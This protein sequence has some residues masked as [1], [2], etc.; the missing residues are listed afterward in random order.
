M[1]AKTKLVGAIKI[2]EQ[3]IHFPCQESKQWLILKKPRP[4]KFLLAFWRTFIQSWCNEKLNKNLNNLGC[5]AWEGAMYFSLL[6]VCWTFYG[7]PMILPCPCPSCS[8]RLSIGD[9]ILGKVV[10]FCSRTITSESW[11][12]V[13]HT[14]VTFM[15]PNVP[16]CSTG[17]RSKS[18][19]TFLQPWGALGWAREPHDKELTKQRVPQYAY[20]CRY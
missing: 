3:C 15:V 7:I 14:P 11:R 6:Y 10:I 2:G 1:F 18:T 8:K 16:I 13:K 4:S 5:L 17:L 19:M 12:N 9:L 20:A